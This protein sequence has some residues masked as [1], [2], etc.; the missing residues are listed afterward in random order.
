MNRESG[1]ATLLPPDASPVVEAPNASAWTG[2]HWPTLPWLLRLLGATAVTAAVAVFLFQQWGTG[3][4][5]RR[6]LLLLSIIGTLTF[7]GVSSVLL[8]KEPKGART[9]VSLALAA[10]PVGFTVAA[11]LL[12]VH[13]YWDS[14]AITA[15]DFAEWR[16]ENPQMTLIA[17]VGGVVALSLV[18]LLGFMVLAR[19]SAWPLALGYILVNAVLLIPLREPAVMS[20]WL[21]VAVAGALALV[22]DRSRRDPSLGT[23]EG[24]FARFLLFIP[25]TILAGRS[26]IFYSPDAMLALAGALSL[27]LLVR[28]VQLSLPPRSRWSEIALLLNLLPVVGAG[29]STLLLV[30]QVSQFH[31]SLTLGGLVIALLLAETASRAGPW[32]PWLYRIAALIGLLSPV[33]DLLLTG[34]Q[35]NAIACILIGGLVLLAGFL[36]GQGLIALLGLV[37]LSLGL[38]VEALWLIKHFN[39]GGWGTLAVLG[40]AAILAGSVAERYGT[41]FRAWLGQLQQRFQEQRG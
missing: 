11:A 7:A 28:A 40:V 2:S 30:A 22:A 3:D 24:R 19:R 10:V 27:H 12:Y 41:R 6:Y 18:S 35:I 15:A 9:F 4:D 33:V 14:P 20:W 32:A 39:F 8:L 16:I 38:G 21:M 25:P 37:G 13:W 29:I 36:Y 34:G 23:L 31:L 17:V 26:L 1:Y 5:L